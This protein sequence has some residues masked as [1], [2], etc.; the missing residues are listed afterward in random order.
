L[1][2]GFSTEALISQ[3][4]VAAIL[5]FFISFLSFRLKLLTKSGGIAVFILAVFLYGFGG[6]MWTVPMV[7]FFLMSSLI[8]I[9]GKNRKKESDL[10]FEKTS[11]RDFWQVAANGGLGG[12]LVALYYFFQLELLYIFYVSSIAAVCADT[13][14]TEIG[15]FFRSKTYNILSF[16]IVEPGVSGGVSFYGFAGVFFGAFVISVSAL[17]WI[18][19]E[20]FYFISLIILAG[21]FG[22]IIDSLLGATIQY[23][24]K[25]VK[26]FKITEKK[27]HCGKTALPV[28]GK[29]WINNDMVNFSCGISGGLFGFLIFDLI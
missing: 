23:Q 2:L 27:N 18:N 8:S 26:C 3:F 24:L 25:C 21:A 20:S 13:W 11:R 7:T 1:I 22:S 19:L 4:A 14:A 17:P 9:L 5:A 28:R 29:K 16:K 15:T 12:I 6:W 10:F